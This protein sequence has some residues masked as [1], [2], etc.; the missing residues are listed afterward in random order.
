[1]KEQAGCTEPFFAVS[2][3]YPDEMSIALIKSAADISGLTAEEVMLEYGKYIVPNTLKESYPT[4]FKLGGSSARDFLLNMDRVHKHA[5]RSILGAT[6]P[7]FEYEELPDG[8]LI[9]HYYSKRGLCTI[10]RG[11]IL[12]VGILFGENLEVKEIACAHK[13]ASHCSM[14]VNFK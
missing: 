4:Y 13:G 7:R 3:D 11:L 9:M 10:L 1:V 2:K 8:R 6:P 14:E 5:T 12:G